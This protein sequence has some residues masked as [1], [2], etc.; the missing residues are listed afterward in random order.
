M[1][2]EWNGTT[3][4]VRTDEVGRSPLRSLISGELP[5]VKL[6][7]LF[8]ESE[9]EDGRA[10][11]LEQRN[12]AAVTQYNNGSLTLLGTFLVKNLGRLDAYFDEAAMHEEQFQSWGF[13]MAGVARER[14]RSTLQLGSFDVARQ[15]EGRAFA[16]SNVRICS[17]NVDTPLHNDFIMRDG[18][19][20]DVV[21]KDLRHQL[22]CVICLQGPGEGGEL[23]VY[24][25][26]WG[27][28]DER[29]KIPGGL[30]YDS[31][32]VEGKA[33]HRLRPKTGD[34]YLL[35]PT[36]YHAVERVAGRERITLGFFFGFFDDA[37]E[38]GVA[39]V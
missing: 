31:G 24:R 16:S 27:P 36:Y 39:W 11:L 29:F 9:V 5:T 33:C 3:F 20:H 18:V 19:G 34:V 35:N 6:R 21:L 2:V 30:G 28:E 37:L 13:G 38:H 15:G 1:G 26:R 12:K 22:S 14:L 25:K 4:D 32:V 23:S 7:N 8:D 17:N 10:R